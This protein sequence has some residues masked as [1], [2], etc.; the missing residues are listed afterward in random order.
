MFAATGLAR[1][2]LA[3]GGIR[4]PHFGP[5]GGGFGRTGFGHVGFGR[6]GFG[7]LGS[8]ILHAVLWHIIGRAVGTIFR[9]FPALGT[10]AAVLLVAFAGYLVV[11]WVGRRRT[12][13]NPYSRAGRGPRDW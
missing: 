12:R 7:H 4:L 1:T 5:A 8:F 10:V 9:R 6:T 13:R 3:R 11:R 2:V